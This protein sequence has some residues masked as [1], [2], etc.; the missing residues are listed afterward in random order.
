[1]VCSL[2][3]GLVRGQEQP[4]VAPIQTKPAPNLPPVPTVRPGIDF[5]RQLLE[6]STQD[7]ENLLSSKTPG[8]RKTLEAGLR[9]YLAMTPEE[10]ELRL[11]TMEVRYHLTVLRGMA[12]SNRVQRLKSLPEK[13]RPLVEDRL[14]IWDQLPSE[15]QRAALE[16]ERILREFGSPRE[17]QLSGQTSNQVRQ[18]E[19]QLIR[20]Q[21]LPEHRRGRI[22]ENFTRLFELTEAE[23]NR[24]LP[25]RGLS[26]EERE[27]MQKA[28]D[29]FKTLSVSQRAKCVNAFERLAE[30]SP[31][32]RRQFLVSA[33]EWQKMKP[34]DR[35]SWRK[36]VSK[37]PPL[38]PGLGLPPRPPRIPI[39]PKSTMVVTN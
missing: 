3:P 14:R 28:L 20:W 34:E 12:P 39:S 29:R 1:M 33:E 18:I 31:A 2:T 23:K 19:Q 11:R 22:Q 7:R 9:S 5:F 27:L 13:D 24:E 30:L 15:D 8:Q 6:A 25:Q 21:S 38:P 37:V 26:S 4:A 16:Y 35:E 17:I 32:E 36:L 10:R